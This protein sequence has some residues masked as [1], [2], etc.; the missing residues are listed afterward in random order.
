MPQVGAAYKDNPGIGLDIMII[1]GENA[2]G[3]QP[4][5]QYCQQYAAQYGL[6]SEKVFIDYGAQYGGWETTFTYIY[7]YL[8]SDGSF[9]LPWDAVLDGDNMEYMFSSGNPTYPSIT[10][11]LNAVLSN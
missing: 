4:T 6:P 8:A 7:P 5:L 1:I 10:D 2:Q 11:A 9:A 3:G